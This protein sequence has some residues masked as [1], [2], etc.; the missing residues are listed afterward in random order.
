MAKRISIL[1]STGSIGRQALD[2]VA[3]QEGRIS[4]V[5][6][7]AG[8]NWERLAE[9][10]ARFRPQMVSVAT[11]EDAER[12]KVR[13]GS[14]TEVVYGEEGLRAVACVPDADTVLVAVTGTAGLIPTVDAIASGK[15]IAL[16]NKETLVAAGELI[17]EMT[18]G[19]AVQLLPVDSE[20]SAVWQCI[21]SRRTEVKSIILTASGGPFRTWAKERMEQVTAADALRH[22]T[23]S[24]G[25][26]ITVDS[27]TL[28]NKGLEVIEARWLFDVGYDEI[29]VL[30]HPQ[31]IVHGMARLTDGTVIASMGVTDMRI[32][33]QYAL[34]YPDRWE[35]DLPALDLAHIGG[36]T[37]EEPDFERFPA[38]RV[39]Y[40]AGRAGGTAPCV[41]NAANEVA[42]NAFLQGSIGYYDIVRTVQ[43]VLDAH[44][45]VQRPGLSEILAAD[46]WARERAGG[47]IGKVNG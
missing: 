33:I 12:V 18:I 26:K 45:V 40:E 37:F 25:P 4:V 47:I 35:M 14:G 31:S 5:G 41:M 34:T 20:H 3:S 29:E 30:V 46:A 17:T 9:Q 38:L 27:A 15:D 22:P 8:R 2:V 6:L 43:Q 19:M 44:K 16:A 42:V 1:G 10:A 36:L 21:S 24:M 28:M 11:R 23:W 32:P 39:A 13:L 7:A